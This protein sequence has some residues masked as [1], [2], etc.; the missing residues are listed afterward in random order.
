MPWVNPFLSALNNNLSILLISLITQRSKC[1]VSTRTKTRLD[2]LKSNVQTQESKL[3]EGIKMLNAAKKREQSKP[4]SVSYSK[5]S[6]Q[7]SEWDA[8]E[9][10]IGLMNDL[11]TSY[12]KYSAELERKI[13]KLDAK[14]GSAKGTK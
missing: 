7:T 8:L 12:R 14:V 5:Q 1:S 11:L 3:D 13:T 6:S 9:R 4:A 10:V 2:Q